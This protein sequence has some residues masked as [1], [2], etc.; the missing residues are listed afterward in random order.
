VLRRECF[1]PCRK[2]NGVE[3]SNSYYTKEISTCVL[4]GALVEPDLGVQSS[5][6][7]EER[8]RCVFVCRQ[9]KPLLEQPALVSNRCRLDALKA[10][11][12]ICSSDLC[13]G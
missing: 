4:I 3:R 10:T 12:V 8:C 2:A 6:E 7:N 9:L 1:H 11:G 13:I 5:K